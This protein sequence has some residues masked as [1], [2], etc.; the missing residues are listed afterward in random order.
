MLLLRSDYNPAAA[1]RFWYH[2]FYFQILEFSLLRTMLQNEHRLLGVRGHDPRK[3]GLGTDRGRNR[4]TAT[5]VRVGARS[6]P[7]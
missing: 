3:Q 1:F 2:I 4:A 5:A 7:F 6:L